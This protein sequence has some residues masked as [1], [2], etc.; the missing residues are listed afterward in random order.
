MVHNSAAITQ[1]TASTIVPSAAVSKGKVKSMPRQA[2]AS[3][4]EQHAKVCVQ[5]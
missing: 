1:Q 2:T 3:Q 5:S 4:R